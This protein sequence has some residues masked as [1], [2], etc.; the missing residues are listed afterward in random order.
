MWSALGTTYGLIRFIDKQPDFYKMPPLS[1]LLQLSP[2]VDSLSSLQ[3]ESHST[4][5]K[6]APALVTPVH[7]PLQT[8]IDLPKEIILSDC[9]TDQPQPDSI[10]DF[11]GQHFH[12]LDPT[13]FAGE[14]FIARNAEEWSSSDFLISEFFCPSMNA[15]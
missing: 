10:I 2:S 6:S 7:S 3:H 11:E 13:T 5:V 8:P 15:L 4:L 1:D 9:H 14:R 12:Y